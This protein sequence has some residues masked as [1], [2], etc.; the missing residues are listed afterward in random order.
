MLSEAAGGL[1]R[2]V[3]GMHPSSVPIGP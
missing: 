3:P 1:G 2:L